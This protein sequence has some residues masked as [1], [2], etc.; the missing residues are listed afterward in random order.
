MLTLRPARLLIMEGLLVEIATGPHRGVGIPQSRSLLVGRLAIALHLQ[1]GNHRHRTRCTEHVMGPFRIH[2]CQIRWLHH[3]ELL[4]ATATITLLVALRA[5][6]Q[7]VLDTTS[8]QQCLLQLD[9]LQHPSPCRHTIG[10]A[11]HHSS[12]R[13]QGPEGDQTLVGITQE[14]ARMAARPLAVD[15]R[16]ITS[17]MAHLLA[18]TMGHLVTASLP[19]LAPVILVHHLMTA[20]LRSV[21]TTAAQQLTRVHN[22]SRTTWLVCRP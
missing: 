4:T 13:Q 18:T 2:G 17:T 5:V 7:P 6:Q 14:I 12:Q 8:L 3:Q 20:D 9:Q 21:R 15:H 10:Q 11:V 19:A 1:D 22:D 16:C